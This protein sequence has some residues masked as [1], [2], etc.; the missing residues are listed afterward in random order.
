MVRLITTKL[1]DG[2]K[3]LFKNLSLCFQILVAQKRL[4]QERERRFDS[5][6]FHV[7]LQVGVHANFSPVFVFKWSMAHVFSRYADLEEAEQRQLTTILHEEIT[8]LRSDYL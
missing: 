5:N 3:R 4:W 1:S 8:K 7:N 6:K 2:I